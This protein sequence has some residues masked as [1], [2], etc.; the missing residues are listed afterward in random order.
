MSTASQCHFPVCHTRR[1]L[2]RPNYLEQLTPP[3]R[4]LL[5]FPA[6]PPNLLEFQGPPKMLEFCAP[7]HYHL[8][9]RFNKMLNLAKILCL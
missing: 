3:P 6:P 4:D 8:L 1:Y 9:K 5:H 2:P 7:P